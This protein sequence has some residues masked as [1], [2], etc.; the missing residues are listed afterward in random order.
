MQMQ[1]VAVQTKAASAAK[2]KAAED[3]SKHIKHEL[4]NCGVIEYKKSDQN[5]VTRKKR[6]TFHMC[7]FFCEGVGKG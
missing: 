6:N 3:P 5:T 4:R 7:I 1:L 2:T